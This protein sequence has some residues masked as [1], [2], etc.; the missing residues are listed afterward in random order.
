[1]Q[2]KL[3][4]YLDELN[5]TQTRL[6]QESKVSVSTIGRLIQGEHEMQRNSADKICATLSQALGRTIKLGDVDEI[7]VLASARPERR[8]KKRKNKLW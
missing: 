2:V 8:K 7:S 1:M 5:W 6:A 3:T 4:T